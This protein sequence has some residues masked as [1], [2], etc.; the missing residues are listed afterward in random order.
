[1]IKTSKLIY[2]LKSAKKVWYWL[3]N[4]KTNV[5]RTF[6]SKI[7]GLHSCDPLP[8]VRCNVLFFSQCQLF[9]W[10]FYYDSWLQIVIFFDWFIYYLRGYDK[11]STHANFV[12]GKTT[13]S[14]FQAILK[15]LNAAKTRAREPG[16]IKTPLYKTGSE[17]AS[18]S[19]SDCSMKWW[20]RTGKG[21]GVWGW[22]V[23]VESLLFVRH[24]VNGNKLKLIFVSV[25][26]PFLN[27]F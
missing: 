8:T 18:A 17:Y 21:K 16:F 2:K 7:V 26:S 14:V 12:L 19:T 13:E 20:N 27:R 5:L 23:R 25:F 15:I 9:F 4:V 1:M 3:R 24:G 22:G 6:R 10:I 11:S